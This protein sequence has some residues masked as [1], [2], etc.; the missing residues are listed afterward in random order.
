[1]AFWDS[2]KS[3]SGGL[4][5]VLYG[6]DPGSIAAPE[7]AAAAQAERDALIAEISGQ[8]PSDAARRAVAAAQENALGRVASSQMSQAAGARGLG[9]LGARRGAARNTAVGQAQVAGQMAP[10]AIAA[11]SA[12]EQADMNRRALL[13]QLL[14]QQEASAYGLEQYRQEQ[15]GQGLAPAILTIGGGLIGGSLGGAQ[16]AQAGALAGGGLGSSLSRA[17]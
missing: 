6:K 11:A 8:G 4:R 2:V 16:G 15:A 3:F 5:D 13:A 1:M 14:G 7:G 12:D 17:F 10:Q 9:V